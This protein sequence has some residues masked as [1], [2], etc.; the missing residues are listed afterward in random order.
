MEQL[1]KLSTTD[2]SY[3]K[4][5]TNMREL[6]KEQSKVYLVP[7]LPLYK[8]LL[9]DA[10]HPRQT[11]I[12]SKS[13]KLIPI[14]DPGNY[15]DSS[16][17][18]DDDDDKRYHDC[19]DQAPLVAANPAILNSPI[20]HQAFGIIQNGMV[21]SQSIVASNSKAIGV[22]QLAQ[23]DIRTGLGAALGILSAG[24]GMSPEALV[25]MGGITGSTPPLPS[26]RENQPL[27][28]PASTPASRQ[29]LLEDG[30]SRG[31]K[32]TPKKKTPTPKKKTPTPK[33]VPT[34]GSTPK[35]VPTPASTPQ[36]RK[37]KATPTPESTPSRRSGR[38]ASRVGVVENDTDE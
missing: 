11:H 23:Q 35:K 27:L 1:V 4:L 14:K 22:N 33:K 12:V 18:D 26:I 15:N 37:A 6:Y 9:E 16:S 7:S 28:L 20:V 32:A 24:T 36:K 13:G 19:G 25:A 5:L 21:A 8:F 10:T 29:L 2:T 38:I 3:A 17:S 31:K 34:P 30:G